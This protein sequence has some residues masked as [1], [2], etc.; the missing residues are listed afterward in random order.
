MHGAVTQEGNIIEKTVETKVKAQ[1]KLTLML[2]LPPGTSSGKQASGLLAYCTWEQNKDA[3]LA[4]LDDSASESDPKKGVAEHVNALHNW[5]LFFGD[6]LSV[7]EVV[8]RVR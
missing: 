4:K 3:I 6:V 8:A 7:D 1:P 5:I 2:R